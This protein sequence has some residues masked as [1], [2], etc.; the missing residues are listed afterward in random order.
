MADVKEKFKVSGE[1]VDSAPPVTIDSIQAIIRDLRDRGISILITDQQVRE[2][3]EITD[4]SYVIR[5]GQVLCRQPPLAGPAGGNR[6]ILQN[7]GSPGIFEWETRQGFR[8]KI[9][10][11]THLVV[12]PEHS[13][14]S[15]EQPCGQ[16]HRQGP[17]ER[18]GRVPVDRLVINERGEPEQ[19][20][21]R[22]RGRLRAQLTPHDRA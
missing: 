12:P 13:G 5:G 15:R 11:L 3:L 17:H 10:R 6:R 18:A 20:H 7:I 1:P 2:T 21:G 19:R 22:Q 16:G 9:E 4:R 14:L 8:I